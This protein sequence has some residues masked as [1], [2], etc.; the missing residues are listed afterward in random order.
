[1]RNHRQLVHNHIEASYGL[2]AVA[3]LEAD[4]NDNKVYE[5]RLRVTVVVRIRLAPTLLLV[6]LSS[7]VSNP[8]KT[9]DDEPDVFCSQTGTWVE[10]FLVAS[11]HRNS[12]RGEEFFFSC[13]SLMLTTE[14]NQ[15]DSHSMEVILAENSSRESWSR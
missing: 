5:V 7:A 3:G 14:S 11:I 9:I 2:V 8:V 4:L 6:L 1:M 12:C 13:F 10:T 15:S